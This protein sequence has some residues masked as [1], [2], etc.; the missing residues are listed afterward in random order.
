MHS[1][2]IK[3]I[4]QINENKKKEPAEGQRMSLKEWMEDDLG[5][6]KFSQMEGEATSLDALTIKFLLPFKPK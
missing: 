5:G 6:F 3:F 1:I 4:L 2:V